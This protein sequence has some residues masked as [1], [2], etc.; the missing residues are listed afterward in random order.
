MNLSSF[1][2][3]PAWTIAG[4]SL[5]HYLWVGALIGGVA[6][7]LWAIVSRQDLIGVTIL[8]VVTVVAYFLR[9]APATA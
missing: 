6:W 4:W 7:M 1:V 5:L 3:S 8:L 2:D 9:R